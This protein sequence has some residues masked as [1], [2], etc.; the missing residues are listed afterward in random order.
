MH[1]HGLCRH[2]MSVCLCV[3]PSITFVSCVKTNKNIFEIISLSGSQAILVFPCQTGSRHA[4]GNPPNGG[5]ECGWG[6]QKRDSERISLHTLHTGLQ[7]CKPYE[8]QSV[9]IKPR[10]T[11]SSQ[12][13][14]AASV[15]VVRIRQRR[16]VCDGLDVIRRRRRSTPSPPD[17]TPLVISP[18]FCCRR[19]S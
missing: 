3:C 19:T 1:K 11:A 2:A 10:W 4:D 14:T 8:S 17:T 12:A 9:K 16:S 18:V 15:A 7:C 13:L 6:R 5:I